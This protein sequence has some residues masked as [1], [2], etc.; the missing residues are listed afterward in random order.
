MPYGQT[1]PDCLTHHRSLRGIM[2]AFVYTTLIKKLILRLKFYHQY[3]VAEFL[4][5]RL[6]LLIETNPALMQAKSQ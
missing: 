3:D 6:V 5:Q 2:V 1:C 4:A